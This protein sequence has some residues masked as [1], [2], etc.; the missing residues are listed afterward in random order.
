MH[1]N[2]YN[3]AG[4]GLVIRLSKINRLRIERWQVGLVIVYNLFEHTS[5]NLSYKTSYLTLN[6]ERKNNNFF[7]VRIEQQFVEL[8]IETCPLIQV[9]VHLTT[10]NIVL[11]LYLVDLVSPWEMHS[12][13]YKHASFGQVILF[14]KKTIT[15]LLQ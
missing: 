11:L 2:K 15:L 4:F 1:L 3:H 6:Y 13:K 12:N 10:T 9:Q 5:N 8:A 14:E 7:F